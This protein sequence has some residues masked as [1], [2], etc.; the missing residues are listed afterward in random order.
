M[1][2]YKG[3]IIKYL[4]YANLFH[5]DNVT[6]YT[7]IYIT[8]FPFISD[9]LPLVFILLQRPETPSYKGKFPLSFILS[10]S[11]EEDCLIYI[12]DTWNWDYCKHS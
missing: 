7:S 8:Q 3:V 5:V 11:E 12:Q 2:H 10:T 4:F 9:K 6:F 1:A